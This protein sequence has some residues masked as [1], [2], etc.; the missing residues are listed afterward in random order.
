M[1]FD[2]EFLFKDFHGHCVR[3]DFLPKYKMTLSTIFSF[4][5]NTRVHITWVCMSGSI[6]CLLF[7]N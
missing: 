3:V 1:E 7:W 6:L 4:C 5:E 2:R